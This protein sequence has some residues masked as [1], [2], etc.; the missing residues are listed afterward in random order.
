MPWRVRGSE[1]GGSH[2]QDVR[3]LAARV[4]AAVLEQGHGLD[5]A[6]AQ[7]P[8]VGRTR[9]AVMDLSYGALRRLGLI[10]FLLDRLLTHPLRDAELRHLLRVGLGELL[11]GQSPAYAVVDQTV[12]AAP[13]RA[14]GLVN[15]VLRNFLRRREALLVAAQDDAVAR[16]N[17]PRWWIERLQIEYPQ[18]WQAILA[19]DQAHPP[20][21]L[22][23]NR[24]R[25]DPQ[26]YLRHLNAAGLQAEQIGECALRLEKPVP[27]SRLPG[28]AAGWVSVQDLGAQYAAPLLDCRDG[29]RVLDACAAPGGKAAHLLERHDLDLTAVDADA[30][31][32]VRVR[33]NLDRL[34]LVARLVAGDAGR[35]QTWWD[36][37]PY[38]RILL[39]APCTASGVVRRHPDGLWLKRAEDATGL[40]RR[41]GELLDALWPLLAPG[42]KLLYATCSLFAQE[43]RAVVAAFLERHPQAMEEPLVIPGARHGQLL[44]DAHH[45]GF[46]YAR[47]VKT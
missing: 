14:R 2:P 16:W 5:R 33:D 10:D 26:A 12:T 3:R 8:L 15:A 37:R 17:H 38:D 13:A 30:R 9:A 18:D 25:I 1:L 21:T 39:D 23:V 19:A 42:G 24:R 28:F 20:M 6:L 43:N 44:P 22:R 31:R 11:A 27:V 7:Q 45:D 46:F 29:M 35:P 34:G 36:A 4:L 40:A 32:L 41:Q 47:L